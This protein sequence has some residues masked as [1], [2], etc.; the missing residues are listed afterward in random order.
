MLQIK[1]PEK[2][3]L[4]YPVYSL[5]RPEETSMRSMPIMLTVIVEDDQI[6]TP[7]SSPWVFIRHFIQPYDVDEFDYL[8]EH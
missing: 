7:V 2:V 4:T 8:G 3:F 1:P 5:H 6:N